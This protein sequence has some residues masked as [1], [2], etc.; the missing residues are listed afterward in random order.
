MRILIVDDNP[1]MAELLG[2]L[3]RKLAD[4][5]DTAMT[6]REAREMVM[7]AL[8]DLVLLD[9]GL[10]DSD[11]VE[12]I[13][14]L[15]ELRVGGAKVVIVTGAWPPRPVIEPQHSGADGVVYKGDIDFEAKLRALC[16]V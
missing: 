3:L 13:N 16:S 10:P 14:R 1:A 5:V 15:G 7:K 8:Y 4:K 6:F 12:T 9:I 2:A 11:A